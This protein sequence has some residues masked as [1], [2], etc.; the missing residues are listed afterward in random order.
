MKR[1]LARANRGIL[2][3]FMQP[4]TLI[5]F[6]YDGTLAPIAANPAQARMRQKTRALLKAVASRRD[7]IVI[8]G[9][10]R[11]DVN[12]FL[13]G[14][15]LRGVIGNHGL[16]TPGRPPR[17]VSRR[18]AAWHAELRTRLEGLQGAVIEDKRY[19]LAVHYRACS[20]RASARRRIHH[21][22]N[23]LDGARLIGGKAVL[24]VMPVEAPDKGIALLRAREDL[25]CRLAL[26][27]G[28]DDTDEDVF[29]LRRPE[30]VLG[31][32]VGQRRSSQASYALH[33]QLEVDDLLAILVESA[34]A[35][36]RIIVSAEN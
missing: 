22:A 23:A 29:G 18:V 31:I 6:D 20:D 3:H 5:A 14:I 16:E 17:G 26:Y 35:Q 30:M 24:N 19:S 9:R 12:R 34:D 28:D 13:A 2:E 33:N 27:V 8:T 15:P 21:V 11:A 32:R 7:V 4:G 36:K 1:I 25:S 10:A